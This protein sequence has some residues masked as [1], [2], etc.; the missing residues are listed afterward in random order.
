[1]KFN[2]SQGVVAKI[3]WEDLGK[4]T[5]TGLYDGNSEGLIRLS[6]GNFLLPE[7]SGLTPTLAMKFLRNDMRSVNHLAN[8]SFEPS[9]SFNFLK[10]D[11]KTRID[12]F[13]NPINQQ[14]VQ[15]KFLE[16]TPFVQSLGLAEFSRF[17]TDGSA[18]A[19]FEFPFD[20]RFVPNPDLA[21]LWPDTREIDANGDEIPWY[22][23]VKQIEEEE[24]L[25]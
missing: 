10:N 3:E 9:D 24:V 5:Y 15:R 1:M 4:H 2:H 20:L 8:T 23:Q 7:A 16:L 25:F 18:V 17:N 12:F 13:Q 6:E 21:S 19:D 22:D 14:T 11:F